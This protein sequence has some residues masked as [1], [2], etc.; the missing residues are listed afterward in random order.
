MNKKC[1]EYINEIKSMFPVKGKQE[2]T[3]INNLKKDIEDYC[4]EANTT[5]KEDLY[6]NYGN[7]IDVVA[8]YFSAVGI[9]YVI[10]KI[11]FSK[12]IKASIA[13]MISLILIFSSVNCVLWYNEH[14]REL[15]QYSA[16]IDKV[17]TIEEK[18]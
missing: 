15:S 17:I 11:K 12:I 5:A 8:E 16:S 18:K 9:S 6:E 10:K 13:V 2:R 3:Y 14:Q 1:K 7:P 4:E